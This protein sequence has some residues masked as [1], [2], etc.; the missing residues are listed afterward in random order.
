MAKTLVVRTRQT[1][2]V[3]RGIVDGNGIL[4]RNIGH[5]LLRRS[6][7]SSPRGGHR[8]KPTSA[9]VCNGPVGEADTG[10]N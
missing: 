10:V 2:I 7:A 8:R 6:C 1:R 5:E 4:D 3:S 9:T